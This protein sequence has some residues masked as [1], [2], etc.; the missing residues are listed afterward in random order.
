LIHLP[1]SEKVP[2]REE[3]LSD[4]LVKGRETILLVDDEEMVLQVT[5]ELLECLGYAVVTARS[6]GEAVELFLENEGKIDLVILDMIM[7]GMSGARTFE[8]LRA[9]DPAIRVRL[10]SG[11]SMAGQAQEIMD[12]GCNGFLQKPFRM[13]ISPGR[14]R[15]LSTAPGRR[16]AAGRKTAFPGWKPPDPLRPAACFGAFGGLTTAIRP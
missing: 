2:A 13:E 7:P 5:E 1:A 14:S 11:Y 15:G 8:C 12:R 16:T 4:T 10:S 6:G 3:A 9:I